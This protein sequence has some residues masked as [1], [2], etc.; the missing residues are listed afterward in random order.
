MIRR[1]IAPMDM[2]ACR[3]ATVLALVRMELKL[4]QL[5]LGQSRGFQAAAPIV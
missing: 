3:L 1:E 2:M 4:H 5:R